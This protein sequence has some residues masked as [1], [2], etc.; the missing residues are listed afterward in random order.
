MVTTRQESRFKLTRRQR[1]LS[2]RRFSQI[3]TQRTSAADANLIV[4]AAANELGF[5]RLGLSVGRKHGNAVRRSRIRR[6]LREAFRLSQHDLPA[7]FDFVLIPRINSEVS[8]DDY[9][10]SLLTLAN[11][12]V[13]RLSEHSA[14]KN[15]D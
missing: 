15:N 5:S 8:L 13:S 10:Q 11:K 2:G 9:R 7:G 6:L 14:E 3:Y 12:A 4:C 1:I